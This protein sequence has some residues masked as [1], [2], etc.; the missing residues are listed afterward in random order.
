MTQISNKSS[1]LFAMPR[2]SRGVA[3]AF[4]L[5]SVYSKHSAYNTSESGE[6]ADYK[7]LRSDWLQVGD[8]LKLAMRKHEN[9]EE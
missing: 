1:Y 5:F 4:D 8:D 6:S 9:G 2:F 3:R 7:A